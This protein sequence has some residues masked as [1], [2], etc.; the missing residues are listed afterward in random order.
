M[1][2]TVTDSFAALPAWSVPS[3]IK[4]LEEP[5]HVTLAKFIHGCSSDEATRTAATTALV[6]SFW[7]LQGR[8]LT[9]EV[10]SLLLVNAGEAEEDPV[11]ALAKEL[12]Y[13]ANENKPRMQTEGPF[14]YAPIDQAPH[15]MLS[16]TA[17][18]NS[19]A[20]VLPS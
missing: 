17:F 8:T 20:G 11:D 10:P 2:A 19:S 3:G 6:L 12:V 16:I 18:A 1:N 7:Q 15:S 14:M 4:Q 9:S 5:P 13:D